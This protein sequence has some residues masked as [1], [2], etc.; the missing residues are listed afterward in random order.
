MRNCDGKI[1]KEVA[2]YVPLIF[3]VSF[4]QQVYFLGDVR[5]PSPYHL[6]FPILLQSLRCARL[7]ED[8]RVSRLAA[9]D[10]GGAADSLG[11]ELTS[12]NEVKK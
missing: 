3:S 7:E 8:L 9:S 2:E 11:Q 12:A 6:P 1:E 4:E 10:R 5:A